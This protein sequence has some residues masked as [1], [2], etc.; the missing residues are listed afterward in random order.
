[1]NLKGPHEAL[2]S[3]PLKCS[4]HGAWGHRARNPEHQQLLQNRCDDGQVLNVGHSVIVVPQS[5]KAYKVNHVCARDSQ[6]G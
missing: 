1:M 5:V 3:Q 2:F 4:G 6:R